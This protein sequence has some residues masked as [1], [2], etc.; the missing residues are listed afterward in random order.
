[1]EATYSVCSDTEKRGAKKG[2]RYTHSVIDFGQIRG[3]LGKKARFSRDLYG[4]KLTVMTETLHIISFSL[5]VAT[6]ATNVLSPLCTCSHVQAD[7]CGRLARLSGLCDAWVNMHI[8]LGLHSDQAD[9]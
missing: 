5:F 2:E 7:A 8:S 9:Q 6:V 1:M 3:D 4:A